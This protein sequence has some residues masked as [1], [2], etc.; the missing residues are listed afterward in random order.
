MS[1]K[2]Q[3]IH[4]FWSGFK[5]KAYDEST[6]PDDA[7][8]LNNNKYITYNVVTDSLGNIN[9]MTASLWHRSNS[10]DVVDAK[11]DEIALYITKIMPPTI[12]IDDG[13]LKIR[14]GNPFYQRM[15]DEDPSLRR[16][17]LSIAAEYLT[18]Y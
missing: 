13:R 7:L 10:W 1:D 16:V 17:V 15:A 4:Q 5:W 9:M 2:Q 14:P 8:Q 18:D 12:K 3:A 6:V 11:S